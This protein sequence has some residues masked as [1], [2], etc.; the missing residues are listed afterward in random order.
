MK[1]YIYSKLLKDSLICIIRNPINSIA[2]FLMSALTFFILG[3]TIVLQYNVDYNIE[4]ISNMP[5]AEVFL[6]VEADQEIVLRL[7]QKLLETPGVISA[8]FVDRQTAFERAKRMLGGESEVM[9]LLGPDFLPESFLVDIDNEFD[10]VSVIIE[11]SAFP[12]TESINHSVNET[13]LISRMASLTVYIAHGTIAGAALFAFIAISSLIRVAVNGKRKEIQIKRYLGAN[14]AFI[15]LPFIFEGVI[16][17]VI[18]SI[19][20]FCAVLFAYEKFTNIYAGLFSGL[21]YNIFET[22]PPSGFLHILL[23]VSICAALF[24]GFSASMLAVLR[25]LKSGGSQVAPIKF[26]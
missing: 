20:A 10:L 4:R 18:G 24:F 5:E 13:E 14:N 1:I 6:A 22:A 8:Q 19:F 23:L 25:H 17:S 12:E 16:I 3:T 21:A 9:E 26:H 2:A 11:I 7:E 15:L